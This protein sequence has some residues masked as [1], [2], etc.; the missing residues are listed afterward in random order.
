MLCF[1]GVGSGVSRLGSVVLL[2]SEGR[3]S[4]LLGCGGRHDFVP[5]GSLRGFRNLV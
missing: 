4:W 2:I 1:V 5:R 3:Q